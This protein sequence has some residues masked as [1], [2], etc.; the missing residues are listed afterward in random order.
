MQALHFYSKSYY[1]NEIPT[2][3]EKDTCEYWDRSPNSPLRYG[4]PETMIADLNGR[5]AQL[6]PK[7]E[8]ISVV[9]MV[10]FSVISFGAMILMDFKPI[11]MILVPVVLATAMRI[12]GYRL[13]CKK[14]DQIKTIVESLPEKFKYSDKIWVPT[15]APE[16][17]RIES[18]L[19]TKVSEYEINRRKTANWAILPLKITAEENL[20]FE[21]LTQKAI[22]DA[23]KWLVLHDEIEKSKEISEEQKT[24]CLNAIK[25]MIKPPATP[26]EFDEINKQAPKNPDKT[27]KII[28]LYSLPRERLPYGDRARIKI[29]QKQEEGSFNVVKTINTESEF[30]AYLKACWIALLEPTSRVEDFQIQLTSAA[31]RKP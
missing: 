5:I 15:K 27:V 1:I 21:E 23:T 10:A 9:A 14:Y 28:C 22:K 3:Y 26:E 24:E 16:N 19:V 31:Q 7:T 17:P 13:F 20:T 2:S 12:K 29:Y 30:R 18:V 25:H 4:T 6:R 8:L 11:T